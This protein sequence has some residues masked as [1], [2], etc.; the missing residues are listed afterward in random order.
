MNRATP[1]LRDIAKRL[2]LYE[3]QAHKSFNAPAPAAVLVSEKLRLHLTKL[4]GNGGFQSILSRALALAKMEVPWLR[5]V[6]V[7][8]DG[9]LH[10][11]ET[12]HR[13]P[14]SDEFFNGGI[15]LIAQL[16]GLLLAFIGEALTL[17]LVR[18]AWPNVPLTDPKSGTGGA[19]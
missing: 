13:Q 16:F 9:S 11:L 12:L 14:D 10:G 8:S 2:M 4:M 5:A 19:R 17:R 6:Q 3:A 7:A 18:E 1:E 15:V